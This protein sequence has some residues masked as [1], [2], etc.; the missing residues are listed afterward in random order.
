MKFKGK[1]SYTL[2]PKK[3][4]DAY[5]E[6][7]QYPPLNDAS[8]KGLKAQARYDWYDNLRKIPTVE[9]KM[10]EILRHRTHYMAHTANYLTNYNSLPLAQYLTHT[11]LINELPQTHSTSTYSQELISEVKD[12]VLDQI[13]VDSLQT[14]KSLPK[15]QTKKFLVQPKQSR[16]DDQIVQNIYNRVKRRLV[17][18]ANPQLLSYNHELESSINS[19]WYHS[20]FV[21]PNKKRFYESRKDDDGNINQMIQ[22]RGGSA[23][24]LSSRDSLKPIVTLDDPLVTEKDVI[25]NHSY[26]LKD[27]DFVYKFSKPVSLAGHWFPENSRQYD[28]SGF[29][30]P[31]TSL[32]ST[33]CLQ[34][35]ENKN[36][37]SVKPLID[38]EDALLTQAIMTG[39]GWLNT[40]AM[41]HGFTPFDE[42]EYPFTC[43][44]ITTDGK[45]WLFNIYQLNS[46][47]FHRDLGGPSRNNICWS[48]GLMK[49]YEEFDGSRFNGINEDVIKL[50]ITLLSQQTDSDYTGSLNIMPFLS[51]DQRSEDEIIKQNKMMIYDIEQR[52]NEYILRDWNVPLWEH[53]FFRSKPMRHRIREMKPRYHKPKPIYPKIFE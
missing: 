20:G 17:L 12:M 41:Y 21:A 7:A 52:K 2:Y 14:R 49:L 46:H 30:F 33:Q 9:S 22:M 26:P 50:L 4:L 35:R 42:V 15:F 25:I 47:A 32:L 44:I 18:D 3:E 11:R 1:P 6:V 36:Y 34:F 16:E 43:Q 28:D 19:W 45:N 39:F 48:S 5:S 13:A 10:Y 31:H 8:P 40:L 53:I 23:L 29:N 38:H 24:N 51:Q 27:Y 37:K